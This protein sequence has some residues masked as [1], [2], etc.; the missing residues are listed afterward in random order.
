MKRFL[1]TLKQLFQLS[2]LM[3]C[4][5]ANPVSVH[6]ADYPTK[7]IKVIV[8]SPPGGPPDLLFRVIGPKMAEAWGSRL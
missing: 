1:G 8:P 7:P 5:I 6:A 2:I 4:V 3:I